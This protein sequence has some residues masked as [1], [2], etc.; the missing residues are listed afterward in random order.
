MFSS[1][2]FGQ[3]GQFGHSLAKR[4]LTEDPSKSIEFNLP[5]V[6]AIL[7][8]FIIFLPVLLFVSSLGA[9]SP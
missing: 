5:L 4:A 9:S 2:T 8:D 7:A 1:G 3:F 6:I